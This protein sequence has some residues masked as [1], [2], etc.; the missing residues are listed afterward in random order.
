VPALS[1]GVS[2]RAHPHIAWRSLYN[3]VVTGRVLLS[4]FPQAA[5]V[6]AL[7]PIYTITDPY[8][9]AFRRLPLQFGGLDFSILPAFFLLSV[10]QNAVASLG[11]EVS[12]AST[13]IARSRM[14]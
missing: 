9:N 10:S 12:R 13:V 6:A 8:L 2:L 7:R 5:G 1:I 4:W 14:L 11:A 3:L